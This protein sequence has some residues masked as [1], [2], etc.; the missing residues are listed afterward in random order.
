MLIAV[1]E[2]TGTEEINGEPGRLVV[3][4]SAFAGSTLYCNHRR[5]RWKRSQG[6]SQIFF[7]ADPAEP[8][9]P[10][11]L[12]SIQYLQVEDPIDE[13]LPE[14]IQAN[15]Q[16]LY[17][18]FESTFTPRQALEHLEA[19]FDLL[20]DRYDSGVL[21]TLNA[22]VYAYFLRRIASLVKTP[23]MD[24]LD[25]GVGTGEALRMALEGLREE[26]FMKRIDLTAVDLSQAM[27]EQ[28]KS[29]LGKILPPILFLKCSDDHLPFS[30]ARFDAV[31]ACYVM[32]YLQDD[33]PLRELRR[34][35]KPDGCLIFNLYVPHSSESPER[36]RQLAS[37]FATKL[38]DCGFKLLRHHSRAFSY[39][40]AG[41]KTGTKQVVVF[42]ARA[43][44]PDPQ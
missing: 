19:S 37:D 35:L 27:I 33:R 18:L 1:D 40:I 42:E 23:C 2:G 20:A 25:F 13:R 34:V 16:P 44:H 14:V 21:N 10:G 24:L 32:H 29:K 3:E 17:R 36:Q 41:G 39:S 26:A 11:L 15:G 4:G 6:E 8:I 9:D 31:M 30:D 7:P 12:A 43:R 28:A 22:N 38:A 5:F